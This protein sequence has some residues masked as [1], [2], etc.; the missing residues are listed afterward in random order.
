MSE[1]QVTHQTPEEGAEAP[2]EEQAVSKPD[3]AAELQELGQQLAAATKAVLESPE[4]QEL[5]TQLQRGLES[6]EKS[7]NQLVGQ[8]RETKVGQ[9]VESG[10]SEATSTVRERR[11]LETLAESVASALH[12]LNQ[13]LGQA[14]EKA[15]ARAEEAKTK[16]LPPQQIEVVEA[17]EEAP[18]APESSEE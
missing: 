15:E 9:R 10:V 14:V 6:L 3:V 17:E 18:A 5:R 11:M 13:S 4:A 1:E 8:A 16:R 2:A 7:V 12:T